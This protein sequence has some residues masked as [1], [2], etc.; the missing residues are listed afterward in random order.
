MANLR[1][2]SFGQYYGSF[3]H[4][5]ETLTMSEMEVNAQYIYRYLKSKGWTT[6]AI[7]GL[8]GNL[9]AESSINSGRWQSEDV[10][11]MS[12]G[13]G[14]VQWT[15]ASKYIEWCVYN[16]LSDPS[17]IDHNLARIIYEVENN[18]QW[19]RTNLYSISFSEFTKS[20][21]NVGYLARAFLLNYERPADQSATVQA[22]RSELAENWYKVIG[23]T[24]PKPNPSNTSKK[25][26]SKF[27]LLHGARKRRETWIRTK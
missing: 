23:G 18:L 2:G 22:Y 27:M 26:K 13:Y 19:I 1:Q 11:N 6:N 7:A 24:T 17:Q 20:T 8:L 10:G 9:Q 14:L 3:Y 12:M 21:E 5:S 15:P 4:E 25:R 16:D